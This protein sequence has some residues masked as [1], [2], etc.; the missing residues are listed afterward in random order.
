MTTQPCTRALAEGELIG[1]R[2]LVSFVIEELT[3]R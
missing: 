3:R 2:S 1:G